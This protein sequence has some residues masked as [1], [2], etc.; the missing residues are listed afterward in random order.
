MKTTFVIDKTHKTVD[1]LKIKKGMVVADI[2]KDY[3]QEKGKCHITIEFCDP[4][5]MVD[6]WQEH[7]DTT[8]DKAIE[9]ARQDNDAYGILHWS[10]RKVEIQQKISEIENN[11]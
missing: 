6:F 3:S 2:N 11:I 4:L 7:I 8:I 5:S 1:Y 9:K 10:C